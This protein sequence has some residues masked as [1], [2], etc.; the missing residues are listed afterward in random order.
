MTMTAVVAVAVAPV[1]A[2]F[3][4]F[5]RPVVEVAAAVQITHLQF[6]LMK[7]TAEAVAAEAV[8][9]VPIHRRGTPSAEV[10][11][12]VVQTSPI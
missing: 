6:H 5:Q 1:P 10:V 7:M 4:P 2:K 3:R 11:E 12:A 8:V 9:E